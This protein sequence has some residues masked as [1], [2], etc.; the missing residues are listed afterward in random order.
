MQAI[1]KTEMPSDHDLMLG[2]QSGDAAAFEVL[3]ERYQQAIRTYLLK[4]LH[5]EPAAD[6][7]VQE[8]FLRVWT[9]AGQWSGSGP[10]KAW[11]YRI[12]TNQAFNYLRSN[13]RHPQLAL[14]D[15]DRVIPAEEEEPVFQA[16]IVDTA[17]LEPDAAFEQAELSRQLRQLID[18]LP[19]EKR[20]VF[21][22]VAEME[23]SIQDVAEKLGIPAGTVKSRLHYARHQLN[24]V[25]RELEIE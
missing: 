25:R 2:I 11:L 5:S 24:Q 16:W 1:V 19:E 14:Q 20:A 17:T 6:D 10:F 9:H 4:I 15:P 8:V 7:L 22:L 3:F 21:S 12:A 23:M 13:I 18:Q